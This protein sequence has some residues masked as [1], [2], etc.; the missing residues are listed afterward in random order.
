MAEPMEL[1]ECAKILDLVRTFSFLTG[2]H[3]T[4]SESTGKYLAD[5]KPLQIEHDSQGTT[6]KMKCP[7]GTAVSFVYDPVSGAF[8]PG[9]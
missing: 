4:Y 8:V 9:K 6:Y 5:E 3:V 7:D 2:K 1:D